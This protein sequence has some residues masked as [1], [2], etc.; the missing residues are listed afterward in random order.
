MRMRALE[1]SVG[2]ALRH[3]ALTQAHSQ[4][5]GERFP[6]LM[7]AGGP[8]GMLAEWPKNKIKLRLRELQITLDCA[9][10]SSTVPV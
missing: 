7:F 9:E 1:D 2:L 4:P 6:L 3:R 8:E 10:S 5:K